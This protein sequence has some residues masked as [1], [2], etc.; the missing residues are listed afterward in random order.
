MQVI[1]NYIGAAL[2]LAA[3]G[4]FAWFGKTPVE[5]FITS[6]TLALAAVGVTH[7]HSEWAKRLGVANP[8]SPG[9]PSQPAGSAPAA[10]TDATS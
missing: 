1:L 5:G 6:L 7:G 9:T 3:W 8:S 2:I 4:L 10:A